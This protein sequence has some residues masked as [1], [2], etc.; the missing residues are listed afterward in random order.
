MRINVDTEPLETKYILEQVLSRKKAQ[1]VDKGLL[2]YAISDE[3]LGEAQQL[4]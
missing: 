2:N 1:N 4:F 3:T